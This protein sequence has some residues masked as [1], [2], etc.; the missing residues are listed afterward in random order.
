[1]PKLYEDLNDDSANEILLLDSE[2]QAL[3]A[4]LMKRFP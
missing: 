3:K 1:M 4:N 2:I